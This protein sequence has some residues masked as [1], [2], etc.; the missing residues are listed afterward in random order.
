VLSAFRE[1][2]LITARYA[3]EGVQSGMT[4]YIIEVHG[5]GHYEVEFSDPATGVSFAQIVVREDELALV[6]K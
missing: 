6:D 3:S 4:G 1:V 2:R 5:D